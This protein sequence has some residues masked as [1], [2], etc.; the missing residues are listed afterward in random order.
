MG[1][2]YLLELSARKCGSGDTVLLGDEAHLPSALINAEHLLPAWRCSWC[3]EY[4][5]GQERQGLCRH[6]V[7]SPS[8]PSSVIRHLLTC[9]WSPQVFSLPAEPRLPLHG[10]QDPSWIPF[11][12]LVVSVLCSQNTPLS[13]HSRSHSWGGSGGS[14]QQRSL[15]LDPTG[16]PQETLQASVSHL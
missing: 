5:R 4:S 7:S 16:H 9:S 10:H 1:L 2:S 13:F 8:H 6:G 12:I 11:P 15:F 14:D 3:R